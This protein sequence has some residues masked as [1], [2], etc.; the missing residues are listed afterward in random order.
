MKTCT[1]CKIEKPLNEFYKENRAKDGLKYHCKSCHKRYNKK[2]DLKRLYNI[3]L[4]Q[5]NQM[6]IDQNNCCAICLKK[7]G[8]TKMTTAQVDHNHETGLV[9]GLLC[10][11]CN[12]NLVNVE[13]HERQIQYLKVGD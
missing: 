11:P 7:F 10:S 8:N 1:K 13:Y 5:Y 4:E 9:R 12:L 2:G 6:V 3:T